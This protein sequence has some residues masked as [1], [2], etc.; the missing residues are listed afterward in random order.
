MSQDPPGTPNVKIVEDRT[1]LGVMYP[2]EVRPGG[3][4]LVTRIPGDP[5]GG[6]MEEL[7]GTAFSHSGIALATG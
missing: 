5:L 7:D 4:L 3:L 2:H 1:S 6:L